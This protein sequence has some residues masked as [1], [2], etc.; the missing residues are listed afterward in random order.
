MK[1]D[2]EGERDWST[3]IKKRGKGVKT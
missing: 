1:E 3:N 2:E